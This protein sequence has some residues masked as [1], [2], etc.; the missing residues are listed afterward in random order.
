MK[1]QFISIQNFAFSKNSCIYIFIHQGNRLE[2]KVH[3][4]PCPRFKHMEQRAQRKKSN[5]PKITWNSTWG[6]VLVV[7][8]GKKAISDKITLQKTL[9]RSR[10]TLYSLIIFNDTTWMPATF[11]RHR[12]Y[13]D[14]G[15]GICFSLG[16]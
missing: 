8:C 2:R 11:Q 4:Q 16:S 7:G 1:S 12:I 6:V 3:S 5:L 15:E 10:K 9:Q 14:L 13:T